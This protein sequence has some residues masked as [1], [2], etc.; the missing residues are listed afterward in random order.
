MQFRHLNKVL[1]TTAVTFCSIFAAGQPVQ[2]IDFR[3]P[4]SDWT[5]V[6]DS[7]RDGTDGKLNGVG[8]SSAFEMFGMAFKEVEDELFIG[9]NSNLGLEGQYR[10]NVSDDQNIGWGDMFFN[11]TSGNLQEASAQEQLFGIRFAG[12]NDSGV[13]ETGVYSNVKGMNV[14]STNKGWSKFNQYKNWVN[15]TAKDKL[16]DENGTV[17][18][19]GEKGEVGFGDLTVEEASQYFNPENENRKTLN[20]IQSGTKIGDIT[21]LTNQELETLAFA[22]DNDPEYTQAKTFG[23]KFNRNLLPDGDALISLLA[24]CIND[25]MAMKIHFEKNGSGISP[26]DVPEPSSIVSLGLISLALAG[27]R[28]KSKQ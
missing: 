2:A 16:T 26:E 13:S 19:V 8:R 6:N 4:T 18:N 21:M 3:T 27:I 15:N 11:F 24:E 14:T 1:A 10:S 12:T 5:Y 17:I 7:A 23:F 20:S 28:K 9:I 25:G 22:T